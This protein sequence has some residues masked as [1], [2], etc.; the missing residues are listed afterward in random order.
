MQDEK[1]SS[2]KAFTEEI[3]VS[4]Q[5]L[6]EEIRRLIGEGNV[7]KLVVK[8][9]DGSVLLTLPLTAGALAGGLVTLGAPWLAVLAAL[10][11]VVAK[12]RIEISRD[13]PPA[14]RKQ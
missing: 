4:G 1:K 2:W 8:T 5:H 13:G 10:A 3:E 14:D 9:D 6:V 11:G 7:R 12:V